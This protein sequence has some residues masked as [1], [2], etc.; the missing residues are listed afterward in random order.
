[1]QGFDLCWVAGDHLV[2]GQALTGHEVAHRPLQGA[3]ELVSAAAAGAGGERHAL[4][5]GDGDVVFLSGYVSLDC[6]CD[7]SRGPRKVARAVL[8]GRTRRETTGILGVRETHVVSLTAGEAS[9]D[10]RHEVSR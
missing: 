7:R 3:R 4:L 1:M 2:L 9:L 8:N 6:S 10:P 5:A